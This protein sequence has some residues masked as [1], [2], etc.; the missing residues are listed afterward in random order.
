MINVNNVSLSF[1][2]QVLFQNVNLS[3]T[4]GNCYGV[5][6]A[7]GAGKSTF[8]KVLSSKI[9]PSSGD[10]SIDKKKRLAF[11]E[12]EQ[13]KYDKQTVLDTV[14][15]GYPLLFKILKERDA[16]Y[17]LPEMT[18]EQGLKAGD[19]ETEFGEIGGYESEFQASS[20]LTDLS[21][22]KELHHKKMKDL[23]SKQKVRVLLAQAV[24]GNPDILILDEPTNNLDI[25][26]IRWLE[27]FLLNFNNTVIVVSHDRHFINN[28]CTHITDIDY[29]KIKTFVGN[30]DFWYHMSQLSSKQ[31]KDENKKKT[32]KADELKK[33]IQRFS[34][35]ASKARQA[36]SRK[37]LL[38]KMT[39]EDVPR[40][41]R[42]FPYINFKAEKEL[43]KTILHIED[44]SC[45]IDGS[46][47][48]NSFSM[49]LNSNDKI[50]F[51]GAYDNI[52]TTLFDIISGQKKQSSGTFRWGETVN[53]G[54]FK[55][56]HHH[57][58][59]CDLSIIDW[60]RQY[61]TIDD[62][63]LVRGFLG[64]MLFSGEES[65]KK[66]KVLSGGEKIRCML[67]KLM[68][69]GCNLLILDE[70][71][72]HLDLEAITALNEGLMKFKGIILFN[73]Q[74][75][76]FVNTIANRIIE[77]T[78]QK[79]KDQQINFDEFVNQS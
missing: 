26:S 59:D 20:L 21:I 68:L 27:K 70:P 77:L 49:N 38:E 15:S 19:L 42:K 6:G 73:S 50:A 55:K 7:N 44:L 24:F 5:I 4:Q 34:S 30:Y 71:T 72:A 3:F 69:S 57:L 58:F 13:T 54:Y 46:V 53:F 78:P 76:E 22:P 48:L 32:D 51:V 31:L 74:D 10:V 61:T 35:N 45:D 9:E 66:V 63:S 12:Q 40:T 11:L 23:E 16:L 37:K 47:K 25:P 60:L 28:I 14:F 36:T 39:I 8:L 67:S 17:S 56:N 43:G 52:K 1:G 2:K 62:E 29:G 79:N 18:E 33:F 64:R 65:L 41:S 75:Y